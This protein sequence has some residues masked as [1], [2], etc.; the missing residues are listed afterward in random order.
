M[1]QALIAVGAV[2]LAFVVGLAGVYFAMPALSPEMVGKVQAQRDSLAV[3]DSLYSLGLLTD[4]TYLLLD[5]LAQSDSLAMAQADSLAQSDSL[6]TAGG[7]QADSSDGA[8]ASSESAV[9]LQDSMMVLQHSVAGL[10]QE[11]GELL[12]QLKALRE[13]FEGQQTQGARAQELSTTLSKLEDKELARVVEQLDLAVLELL[14]KNAS[15]RNRTRLL[16][17]MPPQV[18]ASFVQRLVL[19]RRAAVTDTLSG[20][21]ADGSEPL[22]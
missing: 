13:Q 22:P 5:S 7:A 12:E 17:A 10:I 20:T 11:N 4:S 6:A 21:R 3:I 15:G 16:Q 8:F 19:P 18:A 9:V 14:Y 1:K 2:L